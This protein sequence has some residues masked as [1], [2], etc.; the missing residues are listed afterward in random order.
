[1]IA[2]IMIACKERYAELA[3]ISIPSFFRHHDY[4]LFV[5][6]DASGLR[7]L[8]NISHK[9]LHLIPLQNY[10][11][12]AIKASGVKNFAVIKYDGYEHDKA[13]QSLKPLLMDAV[14]ANERPEAT[15]VLSLDVDTYFS[16]DILSIVEREADSGHEMYMVER[17]DKRMLL[18]RDESPGSG[19]TMWRRDGKF[20][21]LFKKGFKASYAGKTGGCQI[22]INSIM[23]GNEI[24]SKFLTNPHLHFVSPDLKNPNITD[25]ELAKIRPAY[26]HLH[27][28]KS[29]E[30]LLRLKRIFEESNVA[31]KM[32]WDTTLNS[33]V[34]Q[35]QTWKKILEA[36]GNLEIKTLYD[37]GV[38]NYG[39]EAWEVINTFPNCMIIGFEPMPQRYN[40]IIEK[41]YPGKLLSSAISNEEG[42]VKGYMGFESGGKSDFQLHKS[43]DYLLGGYKE[44][45]INCTTLDK[46][47]ADMGPHSGIFIWA[48]VEGSELKVLQGASRL[49]K[50]KKVI[51]ALVELRANPMGE[52]ACTAK[53][54][55]GFMTSKGFK[56]TTSIEGLKGHKDFIY[57]N[58]SIT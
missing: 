41:G 38:G 12:Y 46:I 19:F 17:K 33:A 21:K 57:I 40:K 3:A 20:I 48:D 13:Y 4:D 27:G 7:V 49:F 28:A 45:G 9:K 18:Q 16:G 10:R 24:R 2:P 32:Q 37:V 8:S 55:D 25:E 42:V 51:G 53:E 31:W 44:V 34:P 6:A 30:R 58:Q 14:I 47:E 5:L 22:L 54:V 35:E 29:R 11:N 52:G 50:E 15:H 43:R 23:R 26:I 39:S 36:I 1:M 56:A